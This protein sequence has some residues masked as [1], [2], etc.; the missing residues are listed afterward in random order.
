LLRAG[1]SRAPAPRL[2]TFNHALRTWAAMFELDE[3]LWESPY[4]ASYQIPFLPRL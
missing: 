3:S 1:T 4:N 2:T